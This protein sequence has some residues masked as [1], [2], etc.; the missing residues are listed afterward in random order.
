MNWILN[1]LR[2]R[3]EP[4]AEP[5]S[6]ITPATVEAHIDRAGRDAVFARARE[7]GWTSHNPAPL[8]VWNQIAAEIIASRPHQERTLH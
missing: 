7:L 1:L 4:V 6:Q 3:E 5:A 8:W 2:K